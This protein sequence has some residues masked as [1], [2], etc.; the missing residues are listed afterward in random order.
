MFFEG[1]WKCDHHRWVNNKVARLPKKDP[2]MKKTYFV[3]DSPTGP[4]ND[5]R[6]HAYELIPPNNYVL[7]HYL[8]DEKAA[9]P[10]AH[11][12]SKNT[13]QVFI[14]TCPSTMEKMKNECKTSTATKVMLQQAPDIPINQYYSQKIS[15]K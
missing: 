11:R 3:S 8:G 13:E 1:D 9:L 6:K 2:F 15:S 7:I 4:C 5:F 12:N 10:F 14:R